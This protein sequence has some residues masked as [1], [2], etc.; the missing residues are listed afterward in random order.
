MGLDLTCGS[1]RGWVPVLE[2]GASPPWGESLRKPRGEFESLGA[3]RG[4]QSVS[5]GEAW[6]RAGKAEPC[7]SSLP[8]LFL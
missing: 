6:L 8:W 1:Q 2:L 3:T 7:P 4:Q 5:D